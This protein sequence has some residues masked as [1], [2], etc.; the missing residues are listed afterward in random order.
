MDIGGNFHG[1]QQMWEKTQKMTKKPLYVK[2][3]TTDFFD[4]RQP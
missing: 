3:N 2:Q 1:F 4:S